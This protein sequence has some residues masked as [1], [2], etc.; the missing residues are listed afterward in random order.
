MKVNLA[1][2]FSGTAPGRCRPCEQHAFPLEIVF[3]MLRLETVEDVLTQALLDAPMFG[4]RWVI[5]RHV[6][7]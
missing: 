5:A 1:E 4:A 2:A 3:E 7:S 6:R